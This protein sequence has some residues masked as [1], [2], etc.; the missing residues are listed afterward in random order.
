MVEG[1][2]AGPQQ[3][4]EAILVKRWNSWWWG[5]T[6]SCRDPALRNTEH[7]TQ[8]FIS[9]VP[10]VHADRLFYTTSQS[11]RHVEAL[12]ALAPQTRPYTPNH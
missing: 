11:R 1:L 10:D 6:A 12:V 5:G 7:G 8:P 9:V 3:E 2:E 4:W